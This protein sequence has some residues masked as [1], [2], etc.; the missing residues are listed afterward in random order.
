MRRVVVLLFVGLL[1]A[2]TAWAANPTAPKAT[3]GASGGIGTTDA[4]LTGTVDSGNADSAYRFQ[5]G[6]SSSYGLTSTTATATAATTPA[7]VTA[8]IGGLT[9]ATPYHYRLTA[10]NS[11]GMDNGDDATFTTAGVPDKPAVTTGAV[12]G[13]TAKAG[14]VSGTINPHSLATTY[15]FQ[16]GTT[17]AYG[18]STTETSA[19]QGNSTI[20]VRQAIGGLK[21][22]TTYHYRLVATNAMGTVTGNDHSFKTKPGAAKSGVAALPATKVSG[23]GATLN[24]KVNPN[25][26]ASTYV[27]QYGPTTAYGSTTPV[28]NAGAGTTAVAVSAPITGLKPHTIYHFRLVATNANGTVNSGDRGFYTATAQLALTFGVR[29]DPVVF[30]RGVALFGRVNGAGA[31]VPVIIHG[32]AWPF[33]TPA[34]QIGNPVLTDNNGNYKAVVAIAVARSRYFATMSLPGTNLTSQMIVSRVRV[35]VGLMVTKLGGHVVRFHGTIVPVIPNARV[36]IQRQSRNGTGWIHVAKASVLPPLHPG[37][38]L[39]FAK[40]MRLGTGGVFRAVVLP[41]DGNL[42]RNVSRGRPVRFLH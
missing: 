15:V 10:T 32:Q 39:R 4:T 29:P 8:T 2:A 3:T 37:A 33:T 9:P 27:F 36:S 20:T 5:Y 6:T 16:Y 26:V 18:S 38:A 17:T 12:S 21:N 40:R 19:G 28:Q 30:G 41:S 13:V 23:T 24:G 42:T 11:A 25:G 14:T 35:R 7:T 31:G 34:A 22:S 1:G